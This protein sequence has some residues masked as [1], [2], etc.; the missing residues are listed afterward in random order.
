MA[1]S[2]MSGLLT[3]W[4][5]KLVDLG[6]GLVL[7]SGGLIGT[8]AGVWLFAVLL[9]AGQLDLI[10]GL[11]YVILLGIVGGIMLTESVRA[12]VRAHQGEP[13]IV[14]RPGTHAWFHG[15]PLKLRFRQSRIYVS[16]IPITVIGFLIGFFGAIM[17]IG[18]GFL[19]IPAL[20]YL[21]RVPTTVSLATSLFLTLCTMLI[22]TVLHAVENRTVDIVL[23]L[24]LMTGGVIGAQFG[25]RA[26][27]AIRAERLRLLLGIL[28]VGVAIRF[29]INL[30]ATPDEL[31]TVVGADHLQ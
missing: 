28:V 30:V 27:Q 26:G 15:L 24:V 22:A 8:A 23:A 29:A 3:Y 21:M 9:R 2:S 11:S 6:L 16:A 5:R 4:R 14:R 13:P 20:I 7:L 1:A 31:F 25:A 18:G 19:L 17:G 10:V 12:I